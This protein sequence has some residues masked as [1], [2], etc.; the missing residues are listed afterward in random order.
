MD[1]QAVTDALSGAI[2]EV[3]QREF[4]RLSEGLSSHQIADHISKALEELGKLSSGKGIPDY[5]DPWV[6]LFYITW[7]QPRQINVVYSMIKS[8]LSLNT[9]N[10][11]RKLFIIDFGCGA[12]AMHYGV[13]LA[14]ADI[15][16]HGNPTP[17]IRIISI[18]SSEYMTRI[19]RDLWEAFENFVQ[20]YDELNYLYEISGSI[21]FITIQISDKQTSNEARERLERFSNRNDLS[22]YK[23]WLS[24]IHTV[25]EESLSDTKDWLRFLANTFNPDS[26]F[27]TS[28]S[29]NLGLAYD[30][31]PFRYERTYTQL[32]VNIRLVFEGGLDEILDWRYNVSRTLRLQG[33]R[34]AIISNFLRSEVLW[35]YHR[36]NF[37][38]HAKINEADYL[39]R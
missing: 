27:I 11:N 28:F 3:A 25:Y 16:Q 39:P 13:A 17:E 7:Y 21:R 33:V 32:N 15:A 5:D 12:L 14:F 4:D 36:V 24:A 20:S 6:A 35:D 18:D 19:G 26:G 31:S 22:G 37:M 34:S 30:M 1:Q 23:C 10:N 8:Y 38:L 29:G 2:I 9:E